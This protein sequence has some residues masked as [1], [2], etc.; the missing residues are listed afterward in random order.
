[1][2]PERNSQRVRRQHHQKRIHIRTNG[3]KYHDDEFYQPNMFPFE[4]T[5]GITDPF[6]F[7]SESLEFDF[8]SHFIGEDLVQIFVDETNRYANQVIALLTKDHTI[9]SPRKSRIH[10]WKDTTAPEMYRFLSTNFLMA[11]I[12][13]NSIRS[14]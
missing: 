11:H 12:K 8:F 9:E 14:Y 3:W 6:L 10:A 1:M 13:K 7:T 4:G 2:I 5:P